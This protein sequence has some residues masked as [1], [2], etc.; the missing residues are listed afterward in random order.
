VACAAA[1]R[2]LRAADTRAE[3]RG[4]GRLL[5]RGRELVRAI[6]ADAARERSRL[7]GPD[8]GPWVGFVVGALCLTLMEYLA[9]P[10]VLRQTLRGLHELLPGAVPSYDELRFLRWLQLIDLGFWVGTRGVGFVLVPL[11]AC[12]AW[13]PQSDLGLTLPRHPSQLRPYALLF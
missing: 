12:R 9:G 3:T 2:L 6:D 7:P 10:S 8:V 5:A 1:R 4:L 11:L 13:L